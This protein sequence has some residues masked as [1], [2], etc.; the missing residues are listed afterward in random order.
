MDDSLTLIA[1]IA[2][3]GVSLIAII[4][5]WMNLSSRITTAENLARGA[6]DRARGAD[7]LAAAAI[8]KCEF[9]GR[10]INDERIETAAKIATLQATSEQT[11]RLLI[12]SETRLTKAID[13]LSKSM[14]DLKETM[15]NML[16]KMIGQAKK[17][18]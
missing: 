8:A 16:S 11:S 4:T 18:V 2:G 15:I 17:D 6:E 1:A 3:S 10:D 5:F 9:L 7:T 14:D 12:Q 13:D